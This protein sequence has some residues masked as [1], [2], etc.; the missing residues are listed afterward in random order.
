M[1]KVYGSIPSAVALPAI[2]TNLQVVND[3]ETASSFAMTWDILGDADN[4]TLYINGAPFGPLSAPP[5]LVT[6]LSPGLDYNVQVQASNSFGSS[7]LSSVVVATTN[8][9]TAPQWLITDQSFFTGVPVSLD[10]DTVSV[11]A[12]NHTRTYAVVSGSVPGVSLAGKIYSGTPTTPG[13]YPLVLRVSDPYTSTDISITATVANVDT[14]GP[15][16][17]VISTSA[18]GST[19]TTS[20]VTPSTDASGILKYNIQRSVGGANSFSFRYSIFPPSTSGFETG[21]PDGTWDYRCRAEDNVIP[22]NQGTFSSTSTVVVSTAAQ[23]PDVPIN[24]DVTRFSNSRLDSVWAAGPNGAAPT[25]YELDRSLTGANAQTPG[26]AGWTNVFTGSATTYQNTGLSANTIYYYRVRALNGVTPSSG[27]ATDNAS[28]AAAANRVVYAESTFALGDLENMPST[29]NETGT[30]G[31][32]KRL[33]SAMAVGSVLINDAG[34]FGEL[35]A[36]QSS[37]G[38]CTPSGVGDVKL[39][40]SETLSWPGFSNETVLP[41]QPGGYMLRL[42][43]YRADSPSDGNTMGGQV[44]HY[45]QVNI[46]PPTGGY[47]HE[48]AKCKPRCYAHWTTTQTTDPYGLP[49]D[50]YIWM[51]FSVYLPDSWET[52]QLAGGQPNN[53]PTI[54]E[55]SMPSDSDSN[56]LELRLIKPTSG[57]NWKNPNGT[58]TFNN[59]T[60][61]CLEYYIS[62][63]TSTKNS[64]DLDVKIALR[65]TA[66]DLGRWTDIVMRVRLNPFQSSK[67]DP[68][69]QTVAGQVMRRDT[70]SI[71]V[72]MSSGAPD[73]SGNR[74][75]SEGSPIY[76]SP[77]GGGFGLRPRDT[78]SRHTF[79]FMNYSFFLKSDGIPGQTQDRTHP[80]FLY[81]ADMRFGVGEVTSN[82]NHVNTYQ[83]GV[84]SGFN[85][86]LPR[87]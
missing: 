68:A 18:V 6:N 53:G 64:A 39:L 57:Q 24:F 13:S 10:L 75:I 58:Q 4:F 72:W 79:R 44:K 22:A 11:D 80:I 73:G 2:P 33:N 83:G 51:G 37:H 5:A 27:Y 21:V 70:G 82:S 62:R 28:T 19:V 8:P 76:T 50:T 48:A 65:P 59:D 60:Y 49:F 54:L 23:A 9:N 81:M 17:P 46:P 3:S 32:I 20:I 77:A 31:I 43:T 74:A 52:S 1:A 42:P 15:T 40:Q 61:W 35:S 69:S 55:T 7:N 47:V 78:N 67:G 45:E 34:G 14:T 71:D 12:D 86:V 26:A 85:D 16:A 25:S 84:L 66:S 29:P 36:G 56:F 41:R 30:G 63:L 38:D 87:S